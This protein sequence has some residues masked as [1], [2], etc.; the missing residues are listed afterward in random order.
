MPAGMPSAA[1]TA[2]HSL[3]N[4]VVAEVRIAVD[5]AVVAE[6]GYHQARNIARAMALRSSS[7][8]GL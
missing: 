1:P 7:G 3:E 5:D 8:A 6:N 2:P 4:R